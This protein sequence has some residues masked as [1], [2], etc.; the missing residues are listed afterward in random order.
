MRR[1]EL[2]LTMMVALGV[3]LTA[4]TLYRQEP[5]DCTQPLFSENSS[6]SAQGSTCVALPDKNGLSGLWD[7]IMV[8]NG[9]AKNKGAAS[10]CASP[11]PCKAPATTVFG[12]DSATEPLIP[13]GE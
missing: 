13:T 11:T 6:C 10:D 12:T 8:V 4:Y 1:N 9:P 3:V 2:L 7:Y 5:F